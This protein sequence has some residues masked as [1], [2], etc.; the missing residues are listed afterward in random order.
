MCDRRVFCLTLGAACMLA[1]P[2]AFPTGAGAQPTWWAPRYGE[3]LEASTVAERAQAAEA[4]GRE[5]V[6]SRL[7]AANARLV[8][9]LEEERHPVVREAIIT[10]LGRLAQPDALDVLT[11]ELASSRARDAERIISA[12][13]AI[14]EAG[15]PRAATILV[16]QLGTRGRAEYTRSALARAGLAA[17][18]ALLRALRDATDGRAEI[19][20]AIGATGSH[21][22]IPGLLRALEGP[23][24]VAEGIALLEAVGAI[25]DPRARDTVLRVLA[26]AVDVRIQRAALGALK[27][28]G[29]GAG[30]DA[31]EPHL[32]SEDGHVARE[33]LAALLQVDPARGAV[34]LTASVAAS[35]PAEVQQAAELAL[36]WRNPLVVPVLFGLVNEGT[37]AERAIS[38]LAELDGGA[39]VAVLLHLARENPQHASSAR[40]GL[41][42]A[43]RHFAE[44]LPRGQRR[45]AMDEVAREPGT[46]AWLL[47]AIA[48]DGRVEAPLLAA[49]RAPAPITRLQ[50]AH[51]LMVLGP[52]GSAQV[53]P[54]LFAAARREESAH[55]FRELAYAHATGGGACPTDA[56]GLRARLRATAT[57]DAALLLLSG[58]YG[59]LSPSLRSE[60][61]RAARARLT[62]RSALTRATAAWS[63]ARTGDVL[64]TR[65]LMSR[66]EAERDPWVRRALARAIW[67][68]AEPE[69]SADGRNLARTETDPL[70]AAWLRGAGR[71]GRG[72]RTF[73]VSGD[74]VLRVQLRPVDPQPE[75]LVVEVRLGEG[76]ALRVTTFP[77]GL[78][79]LPELAAGTAD[80][81]VV[82]TPPLADR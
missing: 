4:L 23:W 35:D 7:A 1:V 37:R 40:A 6:R 41:A 14:A 71:A 30:A 28:L 68:L 2:V 78:L 60:L 80:V 46:R 25:A 72:T 62:S 32:R 24:Q 51:A 13:A 59:S 58:C 61:A 5:T 82:P 77:D 70:A 27:T 67:V 9:A 34:A 29:A 12:I 55:V 74:E 8:R 33:A 75:G 63:I 65:T 31:I 16:D 56:H 15:S 69:H 66:L 11:A 81:E 52:R 64:A 48:G 54:A 20:R 39:G 49:L 19:A 76:R 53:G 73:A 22:A 26:E 36:A 79:L 50:A 38:S 10:A 3:P 18:P 44:T 47:G 45:E 57:G 42:I 43:L 21:Q 17:L